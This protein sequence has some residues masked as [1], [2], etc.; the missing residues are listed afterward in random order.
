MKKFSTSIV[1]LLGMLFVIGTAF[2]LDNW[3][4]NLRRVARQEFS[5]TLSWLVPAYMADLLLAGLLLVWL[6]FVYKKDENIR[7]VAIIYI[8]VGLG[9]LFYNVVVFAL[10]PTQLPSQSTIV[11]KS[12][13]AFVSAVVAIVGFQRLFVGKIVA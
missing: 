5:G 6:W 10:A 1:S 9:L 2:G 13:S 3:T 8:L 11:P 12:L 4:D 7:A